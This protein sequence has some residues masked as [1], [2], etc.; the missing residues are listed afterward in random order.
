MKRKTGYMLKKVISLLLVMVMTFSMCLP[1]AQAYAYDEKNVVLPRTTKLEVGESTVLKVPFW[2]FKVVWESSNVNVATVSDNG[3]VKGVTPGSAVITATSKTLWNIFT[4]STTKNEFHVTITDRTTPEPDVTELAV[5]ESATLSVS[6]RDGKT[7]WETSDSS[8]VSVNA[9]GVITGMVEGNATITA[10]TKSYLHSFW[11]FKWGERKYIT[12]FEVVVKNPEPVPENYTV[13]FD[14]NGGSAID[15]QTIAEGQ[16][17]LKPADPVK[18]GYEFSGWYTDNT[19]EHAYNFDLPVNND[20]TVYAEWIKLGDEEIY[21]RGQWI[22]MLAEMVGMSAADVNGEYYFSDTAEDANADIIETAQAYG[23]LPPAQLDDLEQDVPKFYPNET[24]T[25][26]F[27][28]Y[29]AVKAMGFSG[30]HQ[31]DVSGW[32]DL[33]E[34]YYKDEAAIAVGFE[35]LRLVDNKFEPELPLNGTDVSLIERAINKLNMSVELDEDEFKEDIGYVESVIKD[36]ISDITDYTVIENDDGTYQIILPKTEKTRQLQVENVIVLPA[37]SEYTMGMALKI[38]TIEETDSNII[39]VG[40]A[41]EFEEVFTYID[42]AGYGTPDVDA[43]SVSE[44]VN[45]EYVPNEVRSRAAT[46]GTIAVPGEFKL[47]IPSKEISD[48]FKISGSATIKVPEITAICD[49]SFG[50]FSGI[51]MNELTLAINEKIDITGSLDC[52]LLE[53]GYELT[54]SLGNTRFE[55]GRIELFRLPIS[56]GTTGF[57]FDIVFYFDASAKA[58]AKITYSI[59]AKQG[60]QY[61]DGAFR[62]ISHFYSDLSIDVLK[63]SA[64]AGVG[65]SGIL[66]AFKIMDL[67]GYYGEVGIGLNASFTVHTLTSDTLYCSDITT[68]MYAKNGLDK[69]T[70]VG[71]FLD[72]IFHYSLEFNPLKNDDKNPFKKKLHIEN[73]LRVDNCT[74]GHGTLE[75]LVKENGTN[76]PIEGARVQIYNGDYVIR[77]LYTNGSGQYSVDNLSDGKYNVVISASGYFKYDIK[78]EVVKNQVTYLESALMVDR[79][80]I[81]LGEISGNITNALTGSGISNTKYFLRKGW[82]NTTG[83][84]VATGDFEEKTYKLSLEPG[85]YTLQITKEGYISNFVNIAVNGGA[86]YTKNVVLSPEDIGVLDG[87]IR[88]VLTWGATPSDLDSHLF[89]PSGDGSSRF[90]VYYS[91]KNHH[92]DGEVAANLDLDDTSSYGP[93]TTTIYDSVSIDGMYSFYVHNFSNRNSSSSTVLSNSDAKV[94]VYVDNNL[95]YTFNIPEGN[96]GTAWHVF[97]YDSVTDTIIPVNE[98]SYQ[99]SIREDLGLAA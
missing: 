10:T 40:I 30:D 56:I 52:T 5:G 88:I 78:A 77:T 11:I 50:L 87:N 2:N 47:S 90:H 67:V 65:I 99:S 55:K 20:F 6:G 86:C 82:N 73:G 62:D 28:A 93:E 71:K 4:A 38:S 57:S 76:E 19:M 89:G 33:D 7:T 39:L 46:G 92:E 21:T 97:D 81:G 80:G 49:A 29:T 70:V 36:D 83:E 42:F 94:Q 1:A 8:I 26:E 54:N 98:F 31:F 35:F 75:G 14:S 18:E 43:I 91:D 25:R 15:N 37:N 96:E 9:E 27:A 16:K 64:T 24:A 12:N 17:V 68:Y 48:F 22:A 84:T 44:G 95:I 34:I 63:G 53:T 51:S 60:V 58:T 85:N 69:E 61:K 79:N 13:T 74:F 72:K 66:C 23:I 32:D 59:D 3:E 41:P 45:V